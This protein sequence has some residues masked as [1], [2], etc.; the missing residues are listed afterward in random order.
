MSSEDTSAAKAGSHA[1][2]QTSE[3]QDAIHENVERSSA[4]TSGTLPAV[5]NLLDK[6]GAVGKQFKGLVPLHNLVL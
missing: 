5:G 2:R 3:F 1:G 6:D 4:A